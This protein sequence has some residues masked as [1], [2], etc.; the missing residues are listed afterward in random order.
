IAFSSR[1]FD[2]QMRFFFIL[3]LLLVTA[4]TGNCKTKH[5]TEPTTTMNTYIKDTSEV[6]ERTFEYDQDCY[7]GCAVPCVRTKAEIGG[8]L[9]TMYHCSMPLPPKD[10]S[11]LATIRGSYFLL[12]LSSIV[13]ASISLFIVI[14]LSASGSPFA[15]Q[16]TSSRGNRIGP[17]STKR[18]RKDSRRI[19]KRTQSREDLFH[20][21]TF[22]PFVPLLDCPVV[23]SPPPIV[24]HLSDPSAPIFIAHSQRVFRP[25]LLPPP[26]PDPIFRFSHHKSFLSLGKP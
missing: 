12:I 22:H 25:P 10:G 8:Y 18:A 17:K 21:G 4:L 26:T 6:R 13:V 20:S 1:L 14:S 16:S 15:S 7:S 19:W 11:L 5:S 3:F 24:I 9:Q 23:P 2:S